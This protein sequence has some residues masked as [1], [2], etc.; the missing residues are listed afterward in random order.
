MGKK[1]TG[2]PCPPWLVAIGMILLAVEGTVVLYSVA[3]LITYIV[4]GGDD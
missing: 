3:C 4:V 2:K 1:V